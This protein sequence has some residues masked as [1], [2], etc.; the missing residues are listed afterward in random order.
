[1]LMLRYGLGADAAFQ[2]LSKLSQEANIKLRMIAE[3]IVTDTEA[4]EAVLDYMDKARP[5]IDPHK[6][7]RRFPRARPNNGQQVTGRV[8]G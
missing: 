8:T 2:L 5:R 3:R 1:M 4:R 7:K 6:V